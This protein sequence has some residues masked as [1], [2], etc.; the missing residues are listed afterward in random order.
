MYAY[1]RASNSISSACI[2]IGLYPTAQL[3]CKYERIY[4]R[5][6]ASGI[7]AVVTELTVTLSSKVAY[8]CF[9]NLIKVLFV[10]KKGAHFHLMHRQFGHD[11]HKK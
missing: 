3:A 6:Y 11:C 10:L 5:I 1:L 7:Q 8:E 4:A 9:P 2:K